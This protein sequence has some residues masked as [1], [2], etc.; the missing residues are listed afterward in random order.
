MFFRQRRHFIVRAAGDCKAA[1]VSIG[2]SERQGEEPPADTVARGCQTP[3]RAAASGSRSS[4]DL[5]VGEKA[6]VSRG[7]AKLG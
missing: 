7:V 4:R 1:V 6:P 5:I 3:N 2:H